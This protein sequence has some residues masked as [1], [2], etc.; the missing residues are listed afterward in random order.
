MGT[1]R[2]KIAKNKHFVREIVCRKRGARKHGMQAK[3]TAAGS[4]AAVW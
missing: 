3:R 4:P 2:R 1:V